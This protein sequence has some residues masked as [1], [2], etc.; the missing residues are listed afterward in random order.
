MQIYQDNID[1]NYVIDTLIEWIYFGNI[2]RCNGHS[3]VYVSVKSVY[4][5]F[6]HFKY[7]YKLFSYNYVNVY[8]SYLVMYVS[9]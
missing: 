7:F 9:D 4:F 5:I 8:S 6:V 3:Q 1:V 2:V